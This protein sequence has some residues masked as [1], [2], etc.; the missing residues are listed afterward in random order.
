MSRVT[1]V[2]VSE[3]PIAFSAP[4]TLDSVQ[5]TDLFLHEGPQGQPEIGMYSLNGGAFSS[6][7]SVGG[8]N[9]ALTFN[10]FQS[11]INSI[12]FKSSND[13]WS[14]YS[15]KGLTYQ[16]QSVPEPSTLLLLGAGFVGLAAWRW[17]RAA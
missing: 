13:G 15:V 14:D 4:V 9:G 8:I 11:G 17:K 2:H 7:T 16:T 12:L 10:V 1:H 6:F 3:L 5:I